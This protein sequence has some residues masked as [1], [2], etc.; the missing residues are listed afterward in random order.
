[1]PT[2]RPATGIKKKGKQPNRTDPSS[3]TNEGD[4][5]SRNGR[6]EQEEE[7]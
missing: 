1:M 5:Q 3:T 2:R 4:P 7:D 6:E